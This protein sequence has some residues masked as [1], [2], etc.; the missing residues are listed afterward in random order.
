MNKN[1]ENH[2]YLFNIVYFFIS[3]H[4]SVN[5]ILKIMVCLFNISMVNHDELF[6][7]SRS[8]LI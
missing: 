3:P 1:R 8:M 6:G 4:I 5:I 7:K 2:I